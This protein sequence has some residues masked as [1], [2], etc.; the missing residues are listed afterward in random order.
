MVLDKYDIESF[1]IL[2][3]EGDGNEPENKKPHSHPYSVT[4]QEALRDEIGQETVL[5][6]QFNKCKV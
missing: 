6:D 4:L 2:F 1:F 3:M 5:T